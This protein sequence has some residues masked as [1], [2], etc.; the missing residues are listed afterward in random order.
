MGGVLTSTATEEK[1]KTLAFF[2]CRHG[3]GVTD[4]MDVSIVTDD[5][6][7][8][9]DPKETGTC[10]R[11]GYE[12]EHFLFH[13]SC[14]NVLRGGLVCG[15]TATVPNVFPVFDLID[16]TW[17]FD[18]FGQD[19]ACMTE[20]EAA[21]G[22]ITMVQYG[23]GT[24]DGG[25]YRL[26]TGTNDVDIGATT[27]PIDAYATMELDHRGTF[28][29]L[30][31]MLLRVKSQT[32]GDVTITPYRNSRAGTAVTLSMTAETTGDALRRHKIGMG[33]QDSH[34]SMK[35]QN[36]TASQELHLLDVGYEI[37]EKPSH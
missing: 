11:R 14:D 35:F 7:N 4:G 28:L 27:T 21:S 34:I 10:I 19:M 8:Y 9:F 37:Y 2:W 32:A 29:D 33:I 36:D 30:R 15:A 1:L 13:D 17:S 16:K 24:N 18:S 22:N 6:R 31:K 3:L 20:V 12:K 23:G 5:I 26:N 25:V